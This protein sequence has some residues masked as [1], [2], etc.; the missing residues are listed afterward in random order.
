MVVVVVVGAGR[1][2]IYLSSTKI[3]LMLGLVVL[4]MAVKTDVKLRQ[5]RPLKFITLC[6]I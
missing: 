6:D 4:A 5:R 2:C 3:T 1:D